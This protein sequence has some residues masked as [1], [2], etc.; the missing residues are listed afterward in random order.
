[1]Q[2]ALVASTTYLSDCVSRRRLKIIMTI[3]RHVRVWHGTSSKFVRFAS[4]SLEW[5]LGQ[6]GRGEF[7]RHTNAML[8]ALGNEAVLDDC[9]DTYNRVRARLTTCPASFKRRRTLKQS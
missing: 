1:M 4:A 2:N 9:E 8:A 3:A 6:V 5:L 7:Y